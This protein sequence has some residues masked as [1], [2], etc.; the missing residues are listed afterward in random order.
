MPQI[1]SPILLD[2]TGQQIVSAL[3]GLR[4]ALAPKV[5]G[6]TGIN[7]G[8]SLTRTDDA[9]GKTVTLG[10]SEITSDFDS[11]YPWCGMREVRDEFGNVFIQIPKFYSKKTLTSWQISMQKLE[12]FTTLFL[13]GNGNEIDYVLV[14]KYKASIDDGKLKSVSGVSP[15]VSQTMDTFR[16]YAQANGSGYQITDYAIR[17]IIEILFVIEFATT[18]SQSIMRGLCDVSASH[19]TGGTDDVTTVTGQPTD[20]TNGGYQCKY[21]GIE[22][23]WGNVWE[24]VDGISF[25]DADVYL[26]MTPSDYSAGKIT[27]TYTKVGT[28]AT[29]SGNPQTITPTNKYPLMGYITAVGTSNY[30]DYSWYA[31]GG[32][33]LL[34][35][36]LWGS[37]SSAGLFCLYGDYGASYAHG[38]IG[39]RLCK[40]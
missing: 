11:C 26:S 28:R 18:D 5:Y 33:I 3:N 2:S 31:S 20:R 30:G 39:S 25:N 32:Q 22:D 16:G 8:T 4:N 40:K 19:T 14:G 6:V 9:V 37:G 27:N 38:L 12:G 24:F 29:E 13:D 7:S 1:T 17:S 15:A 23:L 34:V 36:G 21:R 10:T 35:G